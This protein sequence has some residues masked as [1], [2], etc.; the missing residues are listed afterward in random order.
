MIRLHKDYQASYIKVSTLTVSDKYLRDAGIP[1]KATF[2]FKQDDLLPENQEKLRRSVNPT[3][4]YM[5]GAGLNL[6]VN[7]LA[8]GW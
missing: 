5:Y 1:A 4:S 7:F 6:L 2:F 3:E 8:N